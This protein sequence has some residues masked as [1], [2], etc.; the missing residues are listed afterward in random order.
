MS[1]SANSN[2]LYNRSTVDSRRKLAAASALFRSVR[3]VLH[4]AQLTE[5][6][7]TSQYADELATVSEDNKDLLWAMLA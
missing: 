1:I 5:L 6:V 4:A 2:P 3:I 7:I